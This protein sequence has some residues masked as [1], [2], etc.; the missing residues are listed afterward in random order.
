MR[1]YFI[2]LLSL[3]FFLSSCA[4]NIYINNLANI[5]PKETIVPEIATGRQQKPVITAKKFMVVSA[6]SLATQAGQKILSQG[7]SAVDAAIAVQ[8]VLNVVEPQSSGIGGGGFMLHYDANKQQIIAYDG[9]E[10]APKGVKPTLFLNQDNKPV[11]FHQASVGGQA[12][13]VPGLLKM[14]ELAHKEKGKL[15]WNMLFDDAIK[16]AENGFPLSKRLYL[17]LKVASD[18]RQLSKTDFER[19][20]NSNGEIKSVGEIIYNKPLANTFK[21][22]AQNG[23]DVFY[24]GNIANDIIHTVQNNT[25]FP[26]L[27]TLKDLK[28]YQTKKRTVPCV[29]YSYHKI[30][31]MAPP[32]SGGVT[33]MQAIK[34]LER[35]KL[36]DYDYYNPYHIHLTASALRLAYADR[37]KYLADPDFISVP[38]DALLSEAY[39][40]NRSRLINPKKALQKAVA[41]DASESLT[42]Y[43][44]LKTHESP[45]TTHISIIDSFGNGISFTSTIEQAFGAG[46]TTKS[47][48]I[49]NNQMTDFDF[50][51]HKQ[52]I[53]VAN[54][55][56]PNKRPRSSMAP[57]F[58]FNPNGTL[59]SIIGSPGGA[60]IISY[61]MPRI[62][63][64]IH[65]KQLINKMLEAPNMTAMLS[66]PIIELEKGIDLKN[67]PNELKKFG[68]Q[69][70][71][72]D[73]T[74]GIHAIIIE[75]NLIYGSADP[76][77][78][79]TALGENI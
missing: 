27:M 58:I 60:R 14:L 74:S 37:N 18:Y 12:V 23:A 45:S 38:T 6:H 72:T 78:E 7:G 49:L 5:L 50:I 73:L 64:I 26:D 39:I 42:Q 43:A 11:N 62:L 67:L 9:R 20:L 55:I 25:Y 34:L 47:G 56:E 40:M 52:G 15:P 46:L 36:N 21:K 10:T 70:N 1:I 75:N 76:R 13:A 29:I 22:I 32:S 16:I 54:S 41:G 79:G 77:R 61:V 8:A 24:N 63:S 66:E 35:F 65:S 44:S 30:C 31:G 71:V 3:L 19:Y 28:T 69:V 68:Y 17:M 48:F 33:V 2:L 4:D 53:K 57:F 51:P 59:K